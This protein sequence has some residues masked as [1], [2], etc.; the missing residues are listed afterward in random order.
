MNTTTTV[1]APW[2]AA[3]SALP[4]GWWGL[5]AATAC[6]MML[7]AGV[8]GWIVAPRQCKAC[9]CCTRSCRRRI[10]QGMD[11]ALL[12]GD[13]DDDD[14]YDDDDDDDDDNNK[15]ALRK[16][17]K[18]GNAGRQQQQRQPRKGTE[19]W[20]SEEELRKNLEK[21]GLVATP[22]GSGA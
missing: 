13:S 10:R 21:Q 4:D 16:R 3:P 20:W 17:E 15:G 9:G 12:G 8:V 5:V 11:R 6:V 18:G 7:V 19:T 2:T 22:A 14:E 1:V